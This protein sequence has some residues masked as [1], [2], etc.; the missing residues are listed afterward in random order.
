LAS[1]SRFQTTILHKCSTIL[2]HNSEPP[3]RL[4]AHSVSHHRS[5]TKVQPM[6]M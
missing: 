4:H 5:S 2:H 6:Q 3:Y 1:S